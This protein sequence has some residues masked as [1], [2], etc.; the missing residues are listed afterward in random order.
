M[1]NYQK[2]PESTGKKLKIPETRQDLNLNES[3]NVGRW[4]SSFSEVFDCE[5][6]FLFG[7]S[8]TNLLKYF[9]YLGWAGWQTSDVLRLYY[10]RPHTIWHKVQQS[11]I[12]SYRILLW[13]K[14]RPFHKKI[15]LPL[16][17]SN[18]IWIL[19]ICKCTICADSSSSI[20]CWGEFFV[21]INI[22][23]PF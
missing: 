17:K 10:L 1:I 12:R 7:F 2:V 20:I 23:F 19:S 13:L 4:A 18:K 21:C 16:E 3:R 22:P 11:M 14:H 5:Y 8:G 9:K 6:K 15:I